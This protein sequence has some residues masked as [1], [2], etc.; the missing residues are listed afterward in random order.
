MRATVFCSWIL[1][2]TLFVSLRASPSVAQS[3]KELLASGHVDEAI[4]TLQQQISHSAADAESQNLLCRA[5]YMIEEWDRGIA[6]CEGARDLDPKNG[7]YELWLGR[8]YGEKADHA[9]FL[10]ASGLARKVRTSF[11]RAVALDPNSWQARTDLA[12]FYV[13]APAIMG[14]GKEKAR[15]EA[16]ALMPLNPGRAHWVL[17][18]IAE[19]KKDMDAAEREYRSAIPASHD[20][21]R[22]RFD[23]ASFL[24]RSNRL[25]AMEEVLGQLESAPIDHPESL[26]DGANMLL[27]TDRNLPLA[28]RLVRRYFAHGP[29]EEGPAF[30]GHD[31]L[32]QL[33]EKQ[34]D[35][36]TAAEE[37]RAALSLFHAYG[38]A[39]ENL[40][41]VEH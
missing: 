30:K 9:G 24:R 31:L 19:K 10:S 26:L 41:R 6:A 34:G 1:F 20:G 40:K 23:L 14:G 29:V 15:Q 4:Q 38:R 27:K 18:R 13:E 28:V 37:Y 17:G 16:D 3:T 39:A 32:G 21:V 12:E 8:V 11:E 22:A 7:L 25:D 36:R 35:R 5:Y 33:L 2:A